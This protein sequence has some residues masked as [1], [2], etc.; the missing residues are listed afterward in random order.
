MST[1]T[2]DNPNK[3]EKDKHKLDYKRISVAFVDSIFSTIAPSTE[4]K[5]PLNSTS[6]EFYSKQPKE[7][8]EQLQ[9]PLKKNPNPVQSEKSVNQVNPEITEK[10]SNSHYKNKKINEEKSSTP[11]TT[12]NKNKQKKILYNDTSAKN[13]NKSNKP[14][15][16]NNNKSNLRYLNKVKITYSPI[17]DNFKAKIESEKEKK[18]YQEKVKLLENRINALK[19]HDDEIHRRMHYNDI[20]RTY[21]NQMKKDKNDLKQALL[22]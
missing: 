14:L 3:E 9:T 18:L 5:D 19:N 22:S 7:T 13:I 20:K 6:K 2:T 15:N 12:T 1:D 16:N 8:Q 11:T 21:L 17:S 4:K 10:K